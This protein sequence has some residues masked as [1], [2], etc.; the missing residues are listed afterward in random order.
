MSKFLIDYFKKQQYEKLIIKIQHGSS[1]ECKIDNTWKI[2]LIQQIKRFLIKCMIIETDT[3]NPLKNLPMCFS[4]LNKSPQQ[5]RNRWKPLPD[6]WNFSNLRENKGQ[7]YISFIRIGNKAG[8]I[9]F[10]RLATLSWCF[11]PGQSGT[12]KTEKHEDEKER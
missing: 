2:N 8:W 1:Q 9:H 6:R 5:T 7:I 3:E 4:Y 10:H 12:T 11:Q